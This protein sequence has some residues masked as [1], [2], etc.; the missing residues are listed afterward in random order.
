MAVIPS[1]AGL[2]D[3]VLATPLPAHRRRDGATLAGR[4]A[5]RSFVSD[6]LPPRHIGVNHLDEPK[7]V[8]DSR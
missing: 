8:C 3:L 4:I 6:N 7:R 2:S 5:I 1:A